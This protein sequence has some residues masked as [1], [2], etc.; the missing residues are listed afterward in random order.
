MP[1]TRALFLAG[2]I[3]LMILAC[4]VMA[5]TAAQVWWIGWRKATDS[6]PLLI[7]LVI[8]FAGDICKKFALILVAFMVGWTLFWR[9][10]VNL[11]FPASARKSP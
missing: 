10:V 5:A 4:M 2:V 3:S 6:I 1:I 11:R 9:S 7:L 8:V